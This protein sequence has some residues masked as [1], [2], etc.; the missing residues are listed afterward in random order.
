[1]EEDFNNLNRGLYNV[2][3]AE[4]ESDADYKTRLEQLG[5][6]DLLRE[7]LDED[8]LLYQSKVFK[9]KMKEIIRQVDVIELVLKGIRENYK[10]EGLSYINEVFPFV[11]SEFIKTFGQ[12]PVQISARSVLMFLKNTL[13]ESGETE[14]ITKDVL[15]KVQQKKANGPVETTSVAEAQVM[16]DI[17]YSAQNKDILI[18]LI[19]KYEP[20]ANSS[21]LKKM[22]KEELIK[23]INEK[24]LD[25]EPEYDGTGKIT[26]LRIPG[27]AGGGKKITVKKNKGKQAD[28]EDEELSGEEAVAEEGGNIESPEALSVYEEL[29]FGLKRIPKL[30]SFGKI[31]VKPHDLFYNNK[32]A[33][34]DM[35]G[36][37]L[38]GF[39]DVP[40]VSDA[41]VS[42]VL[43][44]MK[45]EKPS[46]NDYKQ[47]QLNEKALFDSLIF[48]S[49][50]HKI[51]PEIP[52]SGEQTLKELKHRLNLLEGEVNA[53]NTNHDIKKELHGVV[54]KLIGMGALNH[55]VARNYL[56]DIIGNIVKPR[57]GKK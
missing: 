17:L 51:I 34:R 52:H 32:L 38:T 35:K 6:V 27:G 45:G 55:N 19:R 47:L 24:G 30:A 49:K 54:H 16:A 21:K 12:F 39:P 31:H 8:N 37:S 15:E 18:R 9:N 3:Q 4:G 36:R 10:L 56:Q 44:I 22:K 57:K 13:L 25:Y 41:F 50:L 5:D 53:G 1:M 33:I 46:N 42:L 43:K 14:N 7:D 48:Q 20:S 11:K 26:K 29:G 2:Q 28:A 23:Y 40:G